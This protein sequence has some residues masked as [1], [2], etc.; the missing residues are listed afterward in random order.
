MR[1]SLATSEVLL[2]IRVCQANRVPGPGRNVGRSVASAQQP[3][4]DVVLLEWATNSPQLRRRC[5]QCRLPRISL[6]SARGACTNKI[7]T[8]RHAAAILST[9]AWARRNEMCGRQEN[10]IQ[11]F[12]RVTR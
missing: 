7:L 12:L 11:M 6:E 9:E 5:I 8:P 3:Q 4:P 2:A 1:L 10:R